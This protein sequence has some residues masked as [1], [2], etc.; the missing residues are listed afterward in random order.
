MSLPYCLSSPK[1]LHRLDEELN[2][3]IE[4]DEIKAIDQVRRKFLVQSMSRQEL[5]EENLKDNVKAAINQVSDVT[6]KFKDIQGQ[7]EQKMQSMSNKV[8]MLTEA[9]A[10]LTASVNNLKQ[11]K[12][13]ED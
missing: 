7:Y 5:E 12:N 4:P 13:K 6:D 11:D 10:K 9:F 1:Q 2:P 8:S 3:D